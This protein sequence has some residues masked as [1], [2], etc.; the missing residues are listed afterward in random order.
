MC[1]IFICSLIYQGT[2]K[3]EAIMLDS[4]EEEEIHLTAEAFTKMKRLRI[5]IIRNAHISVWPGNLPNELRLLECHGCP[6]E[7]LPST[8]RAR[9][10]VALNMPNSLI[11][12][13]GV[14]F[15]VSLLRFKGLSLICVMKFLKPIPFSCFIEFQE[16]EVYGFQKL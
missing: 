7:S 10:L 9:K 8:F 1:C 6:L 14:G 13:L 5:L 12:H 2:S 3:I 16:F 4:P 15:K 11:K